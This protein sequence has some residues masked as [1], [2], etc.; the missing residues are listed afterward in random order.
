M[1]KASN[2]TSVGKLSFDISVYD[3]RIKQSVKVILLLL[4]IIINI[5][6]L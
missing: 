6:Y 4:F 1:E 3:N 5:F 2:T